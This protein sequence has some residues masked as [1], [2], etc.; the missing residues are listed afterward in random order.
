MVP[1][2]QRY[3]AL[4]EIQSPNPSCAY[5]IPLLFETGSHYRSHSGLELAILFFHPLS[6]H[7]WPLKMLCNSHRRF[8]QISSTMTHYPIFRPLCKQWPGLA[9]KFLLSL[10]CSLASEKH[11]KDDWEIYPQNIFRKSSTI[12][13]NSPLFGWAESH[14][15]TN[16][17]VLAPN[18]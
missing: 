15:C 12:I 1:E 10:S 14:G 13:I 16:G 3:V 11:Q 9:T 7:P 5:F 4:N 6:Q 17:R 8:I 18:K 2:T